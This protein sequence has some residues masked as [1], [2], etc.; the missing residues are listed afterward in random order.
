VARNNA[1]SLYLARQ[2]TPEWWNEELGKLK[3]NPGIIWRKR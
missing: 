2:V 3:N 1:G